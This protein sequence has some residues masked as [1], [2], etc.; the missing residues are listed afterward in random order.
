MN[1]K[2]LLKKFLVKFLKFERSNIKKQLITVSSGT[3]T[4]NDDSSV[5]ILAEEAVPV[6]NLDA[7][8]CRDGLSKAQSQLSSAS[9]EQERAEAQIAIEVSEALVKACE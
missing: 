2:A 4:I 7:S 3:V 8:L 5:Q 1:K 9:G 6:E